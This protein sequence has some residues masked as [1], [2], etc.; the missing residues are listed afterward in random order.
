MIGK[1]NER[2]L[3]SNEYSDRLVH[4]WRTEEAGIM[5]GTNT[6]LS[7]DPSLTARSWP[8]KNPVRI[9]LDTELRL[10]AHLKLFDGTVSSI[11]F[12]YKKNETA[13]NIEYVKISRDQELVPQMMEALNKRQIQSVIMEGGARLLQTFIDAGVWDE[14]RVINNGQLTIGNGIPAPYLGINLATETKHFGS[15]IIKFFR[16]QA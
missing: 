5:V 3:I 14:A 10:P 1:L 6:A 8:G 13:N 16:N 11:V 7:D 2:I 4:R 15:D 9:V 12:N